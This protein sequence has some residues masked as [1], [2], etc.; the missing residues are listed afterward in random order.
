M[1]YIAGGGT[2]HTTPP[3]MSLLTEPVSTQ[4]TLLRVPTL[5]LPAGVMSGA[6]YETRREEWWLSLRYLL[7]CIPGKNKNCTFLWCLLSF[8]ESATWI[9]TIWWKKSTSYMGIMP[10]AVWDKKWRHVPGTG[11]SR[12]DTCYLSV[13][14]ACSDRRVSDEFCKLD[15]EVK[16][17][18]KIIIKYVDKMFTVP[19]PSHH[20]QV[21]TTFTE[22][23]TVLQQYINF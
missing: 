11:G 17:N 10:K 15:W 23:D 4:T 9:S 2:E 12:K 22:P 5:S 19:C 8:A 21:V 3:V 6:N 13:T 1:G 14:T 18:T 16:V 20:R 7:L